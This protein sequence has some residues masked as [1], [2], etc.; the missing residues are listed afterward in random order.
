MTEQIQMFKLS[1][2]DVEI[3]IPAKNRKEAFAR[4]FLKVKNG[5]IGLE[6]LGGIVI[7]HEGN[8]EENDVP[9][10]TVPTLWL[11]KLIGPSVAFN[12]LERML[13]LDPNSDDAANLLLS[14]SKQDSWVLDEIKR[15]ENQSSTGSAN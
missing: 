15:L 9:F 1:S 6:Q 12:T 8:S 11:M 3:M 13:D 5:E 2:K 4:F 10:R 7:S 14:A